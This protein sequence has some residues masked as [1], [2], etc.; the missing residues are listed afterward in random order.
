MYNVQIFV[1]KQ[2]GPY[3]VGSGSE[4]VPWKLRHFADNGRIVHIFQ[5]DTML[6]DQ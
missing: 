2:S 3:T 6:K 1:V 5:G 4:D